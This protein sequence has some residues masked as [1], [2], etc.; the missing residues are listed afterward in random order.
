MKFRMRGI[1]DKKPQKIS[2]IKFIPDEKWKKFTAIFSPSVVHQGKKPNAMV[3]EF[4][5]TATFDVDNFKIFRADTDFLDYT[6]NEYSEVKQANVM[7]LRTHS[8]I[9]TGINTYDIEQLTNPGGAISSTKAK[10]ITAVAWN[11]EEGW[12]QPMATD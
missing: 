5:G 8:L 11:N 1:Y 9:K 3:L 7:A 6:D 2:H 10:Y 4:S 12:S